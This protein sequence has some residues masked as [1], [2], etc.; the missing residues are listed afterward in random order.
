M[1][2]TQTNNILGVSLGTRKTGVAILQGNELTA[3]ETHLFAGWWSEAKLHAILVRYEKYIVQRNITDIAI[4]IPPVIPLASPLQQV[5]GKL[6]G[7]ANQYG[8][9]TILVT[10]EDI[11]KQTRLNN[12]NSLIEYAVLHFPMLRPEYLKEKQSKTN[13]HLKMFEAVLAVRH[14]KLMIKK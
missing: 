5:L 4:K 7:L 11:K 9:N 8:C 2:N 10:R 3:W 14:Y 1:E 6:Q 13:Y 12:M